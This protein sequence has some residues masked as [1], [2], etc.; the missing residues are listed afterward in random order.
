MSPE[1]MSL[2]GGFR[3][4]M[5]PELVSLTGGWVFTYESRVGV[6]DRVNRPM[7]PELVSLT[8]WVGLYL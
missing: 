7:R 2:T 1:L 4:P 5:S 6:F 8:G 3:L